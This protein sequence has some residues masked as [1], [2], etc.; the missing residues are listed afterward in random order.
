MTVTEK[1]F[2]I[3][4]HPVDATVILGV[5]ATFSVSTSDPNATYQWQFFNPAVN[6]WQDCTIGNPTTDTLTVEGQARRNG[7]KYHCIV[8]NGTTTLTSNAA[9]LTVAAPI[10]L[11]SPTS[12]TITSTSSATF[13]IS[14]DSTISTYAWEYKLPNTSDW[15][16]YNGVG[17]NTASITVDGATATSGTQYRCTVT[18]TYGQTATS[19]PATLTIESATQNVT[20]NLWN[21]YSV[22][23]TSTNPVNYT[24]RAR[25]TTTLIPLVIM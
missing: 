20:V 17:Y 8:S 11:T 23:N 18:D 5:D 14:S 4:S 25:V 12:S 21:T 19:E 10:I 1:A 7:W 15:L 13:S 3:T 2:G 24:H 6:K 16:T 22:Y 9:T